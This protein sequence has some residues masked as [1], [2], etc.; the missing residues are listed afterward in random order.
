M[1]VLEGFLGQ[2]CCGGYYSCW[3][4]SVEKEKLEMSE[5]FW[6]IGYFFHGYGT[7]SQFF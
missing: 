1:K 6:K 4:V 3:L 5:Y 2:E 7:T